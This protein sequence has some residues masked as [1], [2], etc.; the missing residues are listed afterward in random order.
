[1]KYYGVADGMGGLSALPTSNPYISSETAQLVGEKTATQTNVEYI[2]TDECAEDL[3]NLF[4]DWKP[5]IVPGPPDP[6][7][8]ATFKDGVQAPDAAAPW[9]EF[10]LP[11][12]NGKATTTTHVNAGMTAATFGHGCVSTWDVEN[13]ANGFPGSARVLAAVRLEIQNSIDGVKNF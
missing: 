8:N 9:L 2:A 4:P 1:M 5:T 7:W 6:S 13:P 3:K 10:T 11:T 12:S